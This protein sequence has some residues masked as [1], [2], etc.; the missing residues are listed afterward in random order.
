MKTVLIY[1]LCFLPLVVYN[2]IVW[3]A[4]EP[5]SAIDQMQLIISGGLGLLGYLLSRRFS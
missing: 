1:I 4:K 5:N 3:S 2:I